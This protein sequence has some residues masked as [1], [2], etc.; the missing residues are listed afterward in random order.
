MKRTLRILIR[1]VLLPATLTVVCVYLTGCLILMPR[2]W[3]YEDHYSM[4]KLRENIVYCLKLWFG[5]FIE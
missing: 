4:G 2:A 3:I 5:G 1:V